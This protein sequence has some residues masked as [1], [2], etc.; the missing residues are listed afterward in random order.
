MWIKFAKASSVTSF[1]LSFYS[2]L[3]DLEKT[4]TAKKNKQKKKQFRRTVQMDL[5]TW[6]HFLSGASTQLQFLDNVA[7][8][9]LKTKFLV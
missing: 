8:K 6:K 9:I 5:I 4:T 2:A 3:L 7:L 1:I